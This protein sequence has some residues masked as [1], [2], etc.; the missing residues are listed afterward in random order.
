[1]ES[2]S[3]KPRSTPEHWT[4]RRLLSEARRGN[5]TALDTLLGR[6][7][8]YLL[9][10]AR[11]RI[12]RWTRRVAE[13]GDVVQ[14]ALLRTIRRLSRFEARGHGA[15]R[16][17]LRS[18]VD[19]R[20]RDEFRAI[21]RHGIPEEIDEATVD[22]AA[23]PFDLAALGEAEAQYRAALKRLS[24]RDRELIVAHVELG[25]SNEQIAVMTGRGRADSARVAVSR[26][27]QRLADEMADE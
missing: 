6:Y 20:V 9:G 5:A 22:T 21:R 3:E 1:M 4:S 2:N 26:A 19:N 27:L 24:D 8:P 7:L 23:S 14:D 12:P 25:Y 10:Y 17:Y 15:L 13:T 11:R 16:A 18:A